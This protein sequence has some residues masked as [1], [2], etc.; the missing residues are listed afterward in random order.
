[1][2]SLDHLEDERKLQTDAHRE[3]VEGLKD[4]SLKLYADKI[5]GLSS[6]HKAEMSRL[7]THY[8]DKIEMLKEDNQRVHDETIEA[9]KVFHEKTI[10]G[11]KVAPSKA[12]ESLK[13]K[14]KILEV[15][16]AKIELDHVVIVE[17]H[18]VG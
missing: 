1:M 12:H 4:K 3:V 17:E 6:K 13:E 11:L 9:L 5:S 8:T 18:K 16:H 2:D 7:T 15:I 14:Y 10:T